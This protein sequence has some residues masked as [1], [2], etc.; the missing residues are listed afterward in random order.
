MA[1]KSIKK[2]YLYNLA[3]QILLVL[4]PL[5]TTPYVS[6]V[7]GADGIGEFSY[8]SSIAAYF[9]ILATLGTTT[10]GQ[11]EISYSQNNIT[12]RSIVFYENLLIRICS[13]I[14]SCIAYCVFMKYTNN[15]TPLVA[16]LTF[17]VVAVALDI[18]WFFQ[19]MEEFG[20]VVGR[21][22]IFKLLSV[23]FIF[24]FVRSRDDLVVY[25]FGIS[26]IA[27]IGNIS[28][29]PYLSKYVVRVPISEIRPLRRFPTIISLFIPTIAIQV[30][31]V[32][33][34]TMIGLLTANP[35]QNGYYEQSQ[36][37]A[38]LTLTLVTSLGIVMVPRIGSLFSSGNKDKVEYYMQRSYRFVWFLALPLA[39][40]LSA[41]ADN[42]VPWFFGPGFD[43]VI[44]LLKVF[45]LQIVAIG[46]NNVTGIQYLIPVGKQNIFTKSVCIGA[47]ANLALNLLLI[48]RYAA[49]GAA[50]ASVAAESIIA[51]YQLVVVRKEI[52][53]RNVLKSS[54][55]YLF[56]SVVMFVAVFASACFFASGPAQTM[57]LIVLG[58]V[59]YSVI[60]VLFH[61]E[62]LYGIIESLKRTFRN[63]TKVHD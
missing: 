48:P 8:A 62:M 18:S 49:L 40:G 24:L 57:A 56:A 52:N 54:L 38:T 25:A 4:V 3:Y 41:A 63:F 10:Y 31:T 33:D 26:A 47:V 28:M 1:G 46:I 42:L 6:R 50:V 27:V 16:V 34:K 15:F 59:V 21:N 7:L 17:N 5:V 13:T 30:Y 37:I 20:K 12:E 14:L 55:R 35:A 61:D 29:F 2:N 11:R 23:A 58:T 19:G 22:F 45:S 36:K 39:F 53:V 44:P 51:I 60:L 9:V 43:E 32:L